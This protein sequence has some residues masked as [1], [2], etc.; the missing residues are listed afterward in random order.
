MALTQ[1][2]PACPRPDPGDHR[3]GT[4]AGT[5]RGHRHGTE[6][7]PARLGRVFPLRKLSPR[8]RPGR[9]L[10]P[11][12]A[13]ALVVQ[14]RQPASRLAVGRDPGAA[15]TRSPG[16]GQPPSNRHPAPALPGLARA[17]RTPPVKNVGKPC[18]GEPHARFDRRG[19]E[20]GRNLRNRAS[21]RPSYFVTLTKH[22]CLIVM[23]ASEAG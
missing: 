22:G 19:L 8:P 1:G 6:P 21:P 9:E 4:A 15:I 2:C 5:Y 11:L 10:R 14:E 7:V 23:A 12:A 13:R 16:P 20:T 3:P 17:G 18:A